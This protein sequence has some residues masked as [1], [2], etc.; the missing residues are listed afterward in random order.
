M[1]AWE[2]SDDPLVDFFGNA[3]KGEHRLYN[4]ARILQGNLLEHR[5]TDVKLWDSTARSVPW[6]NYT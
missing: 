5:T 3:L 1:F 6:A 2:P 4:T